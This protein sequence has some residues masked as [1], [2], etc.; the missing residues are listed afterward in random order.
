MGSKLSS[1]NPTGLFAEG[2]E[3]VPRHTIRN[4]QYAAAWLKATE[5]IDG[6]AHEAADEV[7]NLR[8]MSDHL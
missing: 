4:A 7:E 3:P 2:L 1:V 6:L 8:E 5:H